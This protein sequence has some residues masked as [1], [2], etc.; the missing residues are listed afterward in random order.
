MI[1]EYVKYIIAICSSKNYLLSVFRWIDVEFVFFASDLF[2]KT[3]MW[4]AIKQIINLLIINTWKN[5]I[6]SIV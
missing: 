3:K 6:M 4:K 2:I 5:T 1:S